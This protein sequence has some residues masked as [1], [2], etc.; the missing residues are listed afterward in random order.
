[1]VERPFLEIKNNKKMKNIFKTLFAVLA[2]AVMISACKKDD[3]FVGGTLHN[4]KVNMT[5]YD[6]LKS[7]SSK[8]FDTLLILVD[9]A[10][11]K[12]K[13][14]QSGASFFAPTNYAIRNYLSYKTSLIQVKD[15]TKR[16]TLDSLIKYDLSH[17]TDSINVY[18]I[19]KKIEY[20]NMTN[21]GTLYAT[22]KTGVNAVVSFE[23]TDDPKLGYN[24]NSANRPQIMY[25]TFLIKPITPPIV[26]SEIAATDGT[27]V[28]VQTSGIETNNGMLHV[29]ANDHL[30]YFTRKK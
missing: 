5:T 11:L 14:N 17:F 7:N 2:L 8:L 23:Y 22:S 26:A 4:A 9:K 6:Y 21:D 15:P 16:Y 12:D 18:L 20:A 29:L 30:L 25:Y 24:S 13:I 27:R 28:K 1:M 3:Y 19:P 10:G